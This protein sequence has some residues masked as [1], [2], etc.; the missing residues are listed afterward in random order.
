MN[1]SSLPKPS[2]TRCCPASSRDIPGSIRQVAQEFL[3]WSRI[4][5]AVADECERAHRGPTKDEVWLVNRA[6]AE[7]N[8]V[9]WSL[10]SKDGPQ[11]LPKAPPL[12]VEQWKARLGPGTNFS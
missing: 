5:A 6:T 1:R 10:L 2:R 7:V 8:G 9:R 3:D 4:M 11:H 12:L